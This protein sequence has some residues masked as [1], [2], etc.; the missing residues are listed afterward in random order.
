MNRIATTLDCV[1]PVLG[2]PARTYGEL[3]VATMTA[4]GTAHLVDKVLGAPDAAAP[5]VLAY[6]NHNRW[7]ADCECGGAAVVD[8]ENP[9]RGFFCFGCYNIIHTGLP[10]RVVYPD[11]EVRCGVERALLLRPDP[12]V[13]NWLPGE[14]VVNLELEN[15]AHGIAARGSV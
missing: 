10:R 15:I 1:L 3:I 7:M 14:A 2:R 9:D 8:P 12:A 5:P 13:R 11:A 4:L 6:V